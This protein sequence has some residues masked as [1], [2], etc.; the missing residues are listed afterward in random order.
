MM[1]SVFIYSAML[2]GTAATFYLGGKFRRDQ[3]RSGGLPRSLC[4]TGYGFLVILPLLMYMAS[5]GWP[6]DYLDIISYVVVVLLLIGPHAGPQHGE[7]MDMGRMGHTLMHDVVGMLARFLIPVAIA[8][9]LLLIIG[10][11]PV[12]YLLILSGFAPALTYLVAW[13]VRGIE[14]H[15]TEYAEFIYSGVYHSWITLVILGIVVIYP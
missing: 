11:P 1:E 15:P 5:F 9:V 12:V 2:F 7:Q 14:G 8:I 13:E 10:W 3:G 6:T 4:F